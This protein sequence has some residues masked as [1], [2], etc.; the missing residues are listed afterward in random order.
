MRFDSIIAGILI[1]LAV[2]FI[3]YAILLQIND[4]AVNYFDDFFG[5]TTKGLTVMA[6]CTTIIPFNIMKK[7][8]YDEG[9]RGMVIGTSIYFFA[10]MYFFGLGILNK[11]I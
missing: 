6:I 8:R 11:W 7:N 2:P 9:M 1:A 3:S 5:L 10:W 4:L